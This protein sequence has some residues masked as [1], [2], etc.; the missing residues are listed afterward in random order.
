MTELL[1]KAFEAASKL[2]PEEQDELARRLL[3]ELEMEGRWPA[4]LRESADGLSS[5]ADEALREH[6]AGK[7]EPLAPDES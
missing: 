5:L 3:K 6:E 4:A 2:S 7:T 1:A